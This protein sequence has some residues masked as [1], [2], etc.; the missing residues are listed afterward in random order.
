MN[1]RSKHENREKLFSNTNGIPNSS[2]PPTSSN[3][4]GARI[5]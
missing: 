3:K 2:S 4:E 5:S 1:S